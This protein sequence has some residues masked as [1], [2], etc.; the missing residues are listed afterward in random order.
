MSLKVFLILLI[1]FINISFGESLNK[2]NSVK[3][4]LEDYPLNSKGG[5]KAKYLTFKISKEKWGSID[6]LSRIL[7]QFLLSGGAK[8]HLVNLGDRKLLGICAKDSPIDKEVILET[9]SDVIT[10]L[11]ISENHPDF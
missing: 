2:Y 1:V 7:Y 11:S 10:E 9:F 8:V 6:Y 5:K 3:E 4:A